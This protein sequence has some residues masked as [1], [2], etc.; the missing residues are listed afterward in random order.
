[1]GDLRTP[2]P[3]DRLSTRHLAARI[4]QSIRDD[5]E[6]PLGLDRADSVDLMNGNAVH[7]ADVEDLVASLAQEVCALEEERSALLANRARLED[8]THRMGAELCPRGADTYGEGKRDAK[9]EVSR[10]LRSKS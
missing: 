8:W 10:I 6:M 3:S 2:T 9:D 1:M 7:I 4:L 5:E